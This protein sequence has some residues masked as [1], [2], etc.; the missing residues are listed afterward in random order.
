LAAGTFTFGHVR[1]L[2]AVASRFLIA[3]AKNAP[4][5]PG[6]DQGV[7]VDIDDTIKATHG[8][9][10]QGAGYGYT[11]VKGLNALLAIVSTPL[12]APGITAT[13][14][15]REEPTPPAARPALLPMRW[16]PPRHT[17]GAV[18][19]RC[20]PTTTPSHLSGI[21]PPT[22]SSR[23]SS[24]AVPPSTARSIQRRSTVGVGTMHSQ[25]EPTQ[26]R[27][28][29]SG[30]L[31]EVDLDDY[32][33]APPHNGDST[34][35]ME[36]RDESRIFHVPPIEIGVEVSNPGGTNHISQGGPPTPAPSP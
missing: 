25:D 28:K 7:Y 30:R 15:R 24:E 4:I 19:S 16:S 31:R 17:A 2:D 1:Q 8:Y 6:A 26:R 33:P 23:K 35:P 20:A 14:L 3:L 5:L 9:A 13:R 12:S 32:V 22:R 29:E 34:H 10:K 27:T 36:D 18:W 21:P 11:G